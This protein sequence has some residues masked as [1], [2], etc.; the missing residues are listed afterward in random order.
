VAGQRLESRRRSPFAEGGF[1]G[2]ILGNML[3]QF[4]APQGLKRPAAA[5]QRIDFGEVGKFAQQITKINFAGSH[6]C[7]LSHRFLHK[8]RSD[9]HLLVNQTI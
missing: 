1:A 6:T 2:G 9:M 5:I 8:G 3:F 4:F 7:V